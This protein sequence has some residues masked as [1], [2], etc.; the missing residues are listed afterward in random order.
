MAGSARDT[1]RIT[2]RRLRKA[3]PLLD[4]LTR[5]KPADRTTLLEF[6]NKDGC[7]AIYK[8][9][10]NGLYN[11]RIPASQRSLLASKLAGD[12]SALRDMISPRR[13]ASTKQK[14]LVQSGGAIG[15]ILAT[16]LPILAN[17]LYKTFSKKKK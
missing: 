6:L 11:E 16:V 7:N 9:L 8:C 15:M 1:S 14:R 13:A 2:K 10:E 3:Y 12:K 5:L 4:L 17:F